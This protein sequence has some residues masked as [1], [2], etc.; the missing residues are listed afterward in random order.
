[1]ISRLPKRRALVLRGGCAPV[2]AHL[3]MVWNDWRYRMALLV[4]GTVADLTAAAAVSVPA[5]AQTA[6][7]PV[8]VP[9]DDRAPAE[10]AG[11]PAAARVNGDAASNGH[12]TAI[13]RSAGPR[14]PW[15]ER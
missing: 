3:P 14:Y 1:M 4:G 6:P 15:D 5:V 11:V 12:A 8:I 10:L 7:Q 13:R 2:I 9:A